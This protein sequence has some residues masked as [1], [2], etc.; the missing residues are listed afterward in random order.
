M[1]KYIFNIEK[2]KKKIII[3]IKYY[4]NIKYIY[5]QQ[6]LG[7]LLMNFHI[8]HQRYFGNHYYRQ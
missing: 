6:Q 8:I 2:K 5:H 3:Y 7:I 1:Y 4:Y